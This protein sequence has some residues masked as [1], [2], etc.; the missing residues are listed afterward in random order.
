MQAVI[1]FH[2]F[3][4][5]SYNIAVNEDFHEQ[6]SEKKMFWW[7][8]AYNKLTI[9]DH[10]FS[11]SN[12]KY[13]VIY[14]LYQIRYVDIQNILKT[15]RISASMHSSRI[16]IWQSGRNSSKNSV[17]MMFSCSYWDVFRVPSNIYDRDCYQ[18]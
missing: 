4:A 7:N 18:K 6:I 14:F 11:E 5:V 9:I 12:M 8:S 3:Q 1:L 17:T 15:M 13:W 16:K 10:V 2:A